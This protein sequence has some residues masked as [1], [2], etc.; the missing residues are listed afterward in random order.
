MIFEFVS[1]DLYSVLFIYLHKMEDYDKY[2]EM[3]DDANNDYKC[4][5]CGEW[6]ENPDEDCKICGGKQI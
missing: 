4:S 1:K 5:D 6:L 2:L 3:L